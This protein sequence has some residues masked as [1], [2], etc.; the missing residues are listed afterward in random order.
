M[1]TVLLRRIYALIVIGHGTRHVHLAG[2][3]AYPDGTWTT[4]AAGNFLMARR[5]GHRPRFVWLGFAWGL[6]PP[7]RKTAAR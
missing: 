3:T 6:W 1:D 7:L 2:I 4:Q 5:E